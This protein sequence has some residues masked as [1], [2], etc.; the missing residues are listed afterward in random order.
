VNQPVADA[1]SEAHLK[2][3]RPA[4]STKRAKGG[5]SSTAFAVFDGRIIPTVNDVGNRIPAQLLML[6]G[7]MYGRAGNN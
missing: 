6:L 3:N 5:P 4:G 7:G 1:D 2:F